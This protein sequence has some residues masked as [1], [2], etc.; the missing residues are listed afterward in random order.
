MSIRGQA[1]VK[2]EWDEAKAATNV[3][4]HGV[5]FEDAVNFEFDTA[6]E[7]IDD[8]ASHDEERHRAFGFIGMK[9]HVMIYALRGSAIRVIPLRR[10]TIQE[11]RAYEKAI[12]DGW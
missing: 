10:A 4:K 2:F 6:I 7:C 3:R 1:P 9:L 12:E 11:K 5:S 8:E